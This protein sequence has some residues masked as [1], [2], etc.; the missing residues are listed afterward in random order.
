LTG[1]SLTTGAYITVKGCVVNS[2]GTQLVVLDTT[3]LPRTIAVIAYGCRNNSFANVAV[4]GGDSCQR[5][6]AHA[7]YAPLRLEIDYT[8]TDTCKAAPPP[9]SLN[10][11][12]IGGAI[13]GILLIVIIVAAV[14]VVRKKKKDKR[15]KTE[16]D[17]K[18]AK[19]EHET[20]ASISPPSSHITTQYSPPSPKPIAHSQADPYVLTS[21]TPP[22]PKVTPTPSGASYLL[23]NS[24]RLPPPPPPVMRTTPAANLTPTSPNAVA[25]NTSHGQGYYHH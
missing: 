10:T 18:R 14:M 23:T 16:L 22:G 8:Y 9:A 11:Y 19:I 20:R 25:Y 7:T 3:R 13:G 2:P 1:S 24:N 21:S 5:A 4:D 6:V 17:S 15:L 12:Y